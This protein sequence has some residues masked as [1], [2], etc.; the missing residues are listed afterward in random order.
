MSCHL[1]RSYAAVGSKAGGSLSRVLGLRLG[2]RPGQEVDAR[3]HEQDQQGG[4]DQAAEDEDRHRP[5]DLEPGDIAQ[6]D[7][8]EGEDGSRQHGRD[9]RDEPLLDAGEGQRRRPTE[10]ASS[11][12]RKRSMSAIE[13]RI[14]IA[15][16]SRKPASAP[17]VN[18]CPVA[19]VARTPPAAAAGIARR[20]KRA[21]RQAPKAACR[22]A[23]S[24]SPHRRSP[25][26][27]AAGRHDPRRPRS[28]SR[29]GTPR[30]T[31]TRR[32]PSEHR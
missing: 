4:A 25:P 29:R 20:T 21:R 5:H 23:G 16:T 6:D 9:D 22:R 11:S 2:A 32:R 10:P 3:D 13:W 18:R 28:R 17:I 26:A 14:V 27:T 7:E 1:D 19:S 31:A 15:I 8:R 30:R 24:G 12:L